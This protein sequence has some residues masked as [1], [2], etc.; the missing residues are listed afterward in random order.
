MGINISLV[1]ILNKIYGPKGLPFPGSPKTGEGNVI[2]DG[3]VI[4]DQDKIQDTKTASGGVIKRVTDSVLGQYTFMPVNLNGYEMPN[5]LI[6]ITGEKSIIETDVTEVGTVFEKVFTRPYDISII[7]TLIGENKQWPESDFKAITDLFKIGEP[8]VL[9]NAITDY[10]I[11]PSGNASS[12]GEGNF[13]ITKISVLD[14][15]GAE[16]VEVIQIDGRSNEPFE[17]EIK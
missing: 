17:L 15:A 10:F 3:F 16:N 5:P 8:V 1:D 12:S 11:Y 7:C 13:L 14:N 6:I 9:K 2:A 4:P